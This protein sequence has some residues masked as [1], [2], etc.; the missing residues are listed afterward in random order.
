MSAANKSSS[1]LVAYNAAFVN[2][3]GGEEV[4][5]VALTRVTA[6]KRVQQLIAGLYFV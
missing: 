2:E 6:S 4:R 5:N 3:V 1:P